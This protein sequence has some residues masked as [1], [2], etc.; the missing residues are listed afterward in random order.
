MPRECCRPSMITVALLCTALLVLTSVAV[1]ESVKV[2]VDSRPHIGTACDPSK[3]VGHFTLSFHGASYDG[4]TNT[5]LWLY[6]LLWDGIPPELSHLTI[7]VCDT[8]RREHFETICPT[9]AVVGPDASTGIYG[10]K[11]ENLPP[12]S[13]IHLSF[14]LRGRF[15]VGP[16][17][18]AAKAGED[19]NIESICGVVCQYECTLDITCPPD[20]TVECD[21]PM[22]PEDTGYPTIEGT[23]PPFDTTYSDNT[24]AGTCPFDYTIERTWRVTDDAGQS[25][26]C[27]QS[28]AV[29][30]T[31]PPVITCPP[32]KFFFCDAIGD[33]GVAT[34]TDNCDLNPEITFS[35]SIALQRCDWE[36]ILVRTWIA[37]DACGNS[38][39]CQQTIRVE[40]STTPVIT[41]CPPDTT[42]GCDTRIEG[43]GQAIATDNCNPDPQLTY[44]GI[45]VPGPCKY[46]FTV[47]RSWEF[48]DGCCNKI[49]CQQVVTVVDTVPPTL[50]CAPDDT[51]PCNTPAV[52]TDPEALDNCDPNPTVEILSTESVPGPP[53]FHSTH[54]RCWT[55]TDNCGNADTC[56][57]H[58]YEELCE[59]EMCTYTQGGWGSGCPGPQQSNPMST[60]P[61][62]IRDHYFGDVFPSG[63]IIGDPG[64]GYTASW[65]SAA[66]VEAFLPAG[67]TPG[68]LTSDLDNPTTTPA[69]VLAG[70]ILALRLNRE[71]S[72]AGI[73]TIL[74]LIEP[75]PCYGSFIIPSKC[76]K[77]AGM[78]VDEFLAIA[79]QAVGGDPSVLVP[80]TASL[81][82]LN[83]TAT[84]LNE[85]H[86]DCDNGVYYEGDITAPDDVVIPPARPAAGPTEFAL[87][88]RPNP[89]TG[90]T[91]ISYAMPGAGRVTLQIY[92]IQGREIVRLI[93]TY[94]EAGNHAVIWNGRDAGGNGVVSGVYFCR[95]QFENRPGMLEKL[96]KL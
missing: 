34:A 25:K 1:A 8:L 61:G 6:E 35:D 13:P 9:G 18:F 64:G 15:D 55:A 58:I 36:Y 31:V 79:D 96:I 86:D 42:V 83:S 67:S 32:D 22:D 4:G 94:K 88:S 44:E 20:L 7:G 87:S 75:G 11:W 28:I 59:G 52:F 5:T 70:Q 78:T 84:C 53:P 2:G 81:S 56:C 65:D 37:T 54:T 16:A 26:D 24:L 12:D 72:C 90:S 43:L 23:C 45:M 51:I 30:D 27:V 48:T 19:D 14:V 29:I 21:D 57:Q 73:F 85:L 68:V 17:F 10:I 80:Y 47:V 89:L 60:Q 40:D 92:D 71:Y 74:G 62:C 63:V 46:E 93:D 50:T 38:S 33:T 77:F 66:A 69:G 49:Q 39:S 41:Y 76:G 3:T 95:F 82:D 91:T